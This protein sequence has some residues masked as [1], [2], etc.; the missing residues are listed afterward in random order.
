MEPCVPLNCQ[1]SAFLMCLVQYHLLLLP[2]SSLSVLG[3]LRTNESTSV[4]LAGYI[5]QACIFSSG[6]DLT[7]FDD[8]NVPLYAILSHTETCV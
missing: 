7:T 5:K 1:L 2:I 8:E 4:T 6:F 3:L